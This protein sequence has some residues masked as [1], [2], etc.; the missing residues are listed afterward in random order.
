MNIFG[1]L[2][3]LIASAA[4]VGSV[5]LICKFGITIHHVNTTVLPPKAAP[6]ADAVTTKKKD[7]DPSELSMDAVIKAANELMG[8]ET[9]IKEIK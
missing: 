3:V 4:C 6:V 8:I 7:E 2:A 5:Y 9:A 1:F